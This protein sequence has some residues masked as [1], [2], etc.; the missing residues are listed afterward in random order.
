MRKDCE[1]GGLR[2]GGQST[3]LGHISWLFKERYLG[4]ETT[5]EKD[6]TKNI[7]TLSFLLIQASFGFN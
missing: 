6:C 7:I 3:V 5:L 4:I 2:Y 1:N